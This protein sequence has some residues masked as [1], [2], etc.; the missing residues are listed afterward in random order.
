VNEETG[1]TDAI[2]K[3]TEYGFG[4]ITIVNKDGSIKGVFTD[5][6]LRRLITKEGRNILNHKMGDLTYN[7]PVSI[8]ADALLN[9]AAQLFKKTKVDT[10]LVT[11]DGKPVG[12][13]DIQDLENN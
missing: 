2:V 9:D 10:I 5:G 1:L 4:G 3:M 12:M 6:D 11:S 13:I 7:A 8:E